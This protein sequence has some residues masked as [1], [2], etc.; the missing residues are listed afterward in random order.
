MVNRIRELNVGAKVPPASILKIIC[1][2]Y[3]CVIYFRDTFPLGHVC[4]VT[5][6]LKCLLKSHSEE[7]IV[8]DSVPIELDEDL[9]CLTGCGKLG[10]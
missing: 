6:F 8:K 3:Y 9:I 4:H 10:P 7:E 2:I 5:S 1:V